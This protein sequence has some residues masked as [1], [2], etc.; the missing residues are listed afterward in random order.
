VADTDALRL[1]K[2]KRPSITLQSKAVSVSVQLYL[3]TS[4][5]DRLFN[6]LFKHLGSAASLVVS[7]DTVLPKLPAVYV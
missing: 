4:G 6:T 7:D 1:S 5:R 3:N 2:Q